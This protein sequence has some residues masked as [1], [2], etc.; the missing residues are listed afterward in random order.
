MTRRTERRQFLGQ[1]IALAV[2]AGSSAQG[3]GRAFGQEPAVAAG[4][5]A[6]GGTTGMIPIVD[7]HQHLW[8]LT[9]F[10]LALA[11][12]RVAARQELPHGRLSQGRG[13]PGRSQVGLHGSR[14]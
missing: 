3:L 9:K 10:R 7:T 12:G 4:V 14:R 13:G 5:K 1:A 8:D 6:N 2:A 11:D